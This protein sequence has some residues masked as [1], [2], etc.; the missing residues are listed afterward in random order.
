MPQI[1]PSWIE[2]PHLQSRVLGD[3]PVVSIVAGPGYGKTTLAVEAAAAWKGPTPWYSLDETDADLP[4]FAAHV[5]SALR[6]CR[7]D[8]SGNA[9]S[10][11][12]PG[13]PKELGYRLA[14]ALGDLPQPA[15]F[16]FDDVQALEGGRAAIA[17]SEFVERGSRLGAHFVL[18]GRSMPFALH[19]LAAS[20]S[21]HSIT[22]ADLAFNAAEA[23]TYLHGMLHEAAQQG[24]VAGLARR[25]EGWPAGLALIASSAPRSGKAATPDGF[26]GEGDEARRYLFEYLATE[27][28]AS[29]SQDEQRFL[30][31]TSVAA[32]LEIDLCNAVTGD[33]NA[34]KILDSL[35]MR[36]L[37]VTRLTSSA[38]SSHQLFREFLQQALKRS[39][40]PDQVASLHRRAGQYLAA[41]SDF[42]A[43]AEHFLEA[44]DVESAAAILERE[45][46][47]LLRSGLIGAVNN[48]IAR[49]GKQRIE[50]SPALSAAQGR[51]QRERGEWDAALASLEQAISLAH[52]A[53]EYD[54]IAEAVRSAAPILAARNELE[55]LRSMLDDALALRDHLQPASVNSLR[56]TLAAVLL[57]TDML[58]EAVAMYR[59]IT[60]LL[61]ATGDLAAQGLVLHNLGVAQLR[62]GDV[63]A[64]LST[65]ERAAKLKENAGQRV[66]LLHT[67]ADTVYAKT[68]LGYF[69]E[70]DRLAESLLSQARD[71]GASGIAARAHEQRGVLALLRDS[72]V[73]A[74]DEFR[75]A[76]QACDPG[77][78]F[79][80]PEIEHGL[81]QCALLSKDMAAAEYFGDRA[82]SAFLGAKRHQQRAPVLLTQ[83]ACALARGDPHA[84]AR[85]AGEA[86]EAAGQGKNALLEATSALGVADILIQCAAVVGDPE[87]D[88]RAA[89]AATAAIALIHQRD[90]RFLLRTRSA[91]FDRLKPHLRRWGI[92]GGLLP[93]LRPAEPAGALRVEMLG[94]FR[95]LLSGRPVPP[96]SWKRRKAPELFAFLIASKGAP[97]SRARL[98]DLYWPDSDADAAHDSLRV[99]ISA[100]RKAVGDVVQF[101]SNGYRFA[102]PADAVVDADLF[103]NHI[104]QAR[105]ADVRGDAPGARRAYQ[106]AADLYRGDYLDGLGDAGWQWRQRERFRAECLE[107]LRWLA[108]DCERSNDAVRQRSLLDRLLEVAPFDLEAV[109]MRL[110][111][112][113]AD[114]RLADAR[115]DYLAWCS[116]YRHAVGMDPPQVWPGGA[117][118]DI[119]PNA[120]TIAAEA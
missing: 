28:L 104:E 86:G 79:L 29:L 90:Y 107:A 113:V 96:E 100:I 26:V 47:A 30:L 114:G 2:R 71:V 49:I 8:G 17:L 27:V 25:A 87:I 80:L 110:R 94:P 70:A 3:K 76:Q 53:G 43:A 99:T 92:G 46:S 109:R 117:A 4:V 106:L 67:L 55:R 103:E 102:A 1:S 60:P 12:A 22:A 21:L 16:I 105:Q 19:R 120:E 7:P 77:D 51:V 85:L 97:V 5:E 68:L 72:V 38:Y 39:T 91:A 44:G 54:I 14:E 98:I 42:L 10:A 69:E 112:L 34:G 81:A 88:R 118:E 108:R 73:A 18:C 74:D 32:R 93:E 6:S 33:D 52:S 119:K 75:A 24:Y 15:L 40:S 84:A 89:A 37:F 116:S 61:V 58:D 83:A 78:V 48:L 23:E 95:V 56:T 41:R 63:Y 11:A 111:S 62:R 57:E 45:S 20:A 36:G 64:G 31:H 59:D 66:S 50:E 115:R 35:T 65:Y 13:T 9:S 101:Q 82:S